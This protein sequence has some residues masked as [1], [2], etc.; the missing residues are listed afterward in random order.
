MKQRGVAE[1]EPLGCWSTWTTSDLHSDPQP[2]RSDPLT[3]H[4]SLDVSYTPVPPS[5][6][7]FPS[8]DARSWDWYLL[9][10]PLS[11]LVYPRPEPPSSKVKEAS[12]PSEQGHRLPP[13]EQ[14]SCFD[15]MYF[16]SSGKDDFEW[17]DAWCPAWRF[18]GRHIRFQESLVDVATGYV[19]RLLQTTNDVPVSKIFFNGC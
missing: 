16:V 4:L 14:L 18:V 2:R 8:D 5:T 7:R 17:N 11:S 13:D 6:R 10:N 19:Q 15:L 12:F 9:F 1:R 3:A